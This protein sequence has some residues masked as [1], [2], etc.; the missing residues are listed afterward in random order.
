MHSARHCCGANSQTGALHYTLSWLLIPNGFA[1]VCLGPVSLTKHLIRMKTHAASY[2]PT[3]PQL[4]IVPFVRGAYK[5]VP[6]RPHCS[7]LLLQPNHFTVANIYWR[8]LWLYHTALQVLV[9]IVLPWLC[10]FFLALHFF[11]FPVKVT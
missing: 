6:I 7:V 5:V 9:P 3:F 11:Y 2:F 4:K 8:D 10:P 1:K